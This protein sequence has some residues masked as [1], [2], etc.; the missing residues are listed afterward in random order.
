MESPS[1]EYVSLENKSWWSSFTSIFTAGSVGACVLALCCSIIGG[2]L[3][4]IPYAVS[5]CGYLLG[6]LLLISG[7]LAY[8]FYYSLLIYACDIKGIYDY[9]LVMKSIYGEFG[10]KV[11]EISIVSTCFGSIVSYVILI[12]K[13]AIEILL[14]Y[15]LIEEATAPT[16]KVYLTF[17]IFFFIWLPLCLTK[18]LTALSYGSMISV[19]G[20]SYVTVLIIIESFGFIPSADYEKL[21]YASF[22]NTFLEAVGVCLF[23]YDG[24]QN[25][26]IVYSELKG[27]ER[28]TMYSVIKVSMVL[29]I[30]LYTTLGIV[31]YLSHL[32]TTPDIII[33]RLPLDKTSSDWPMLIARI[34]VC[35]S[36]NMTIVAN[37]YPIRI[38][39]QQM[40]WGAEQKGNNIVHVVV[41]L[42][43]LL[44]AII[45][46]IALPNVIF[47]F[48]LLG[49]LFAT[50][51]CV[52]LPCMAYY[53]VSDDKLVKSIAV[54]GAAI[55]SILA[56]G[57]FTDTM[58]ST[59]SH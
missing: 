3:L 57:C 4:S 36:L 45:L 39:V 5:Q 34:F 16:L 38:I 52:I 2:G 40:V 51:I 32:D 56:L 25:I 13:I 49:S 26:P 43:I 28:K 23:A 20:I 59:F 22:T 44:S 21:E 37:L 29:L 15:S 24:A 42:V 55:I 7:G 53:R 54:I 30:I 8:M 41:T 47:Y 11:T 33:S 35:L 58:I 27:R 1:T 31:G 6:G 10:G 18:E 46:A 48:K 19:L 9:S 17:G 12:P 14:T 50:P